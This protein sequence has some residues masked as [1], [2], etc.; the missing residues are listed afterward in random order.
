MEDWFTADQHF[1]HDNIIKYCNRPFNSLP[2]MHEEIIGNWNDCVT[3]HDRVFVL[4]DFAFCNGVEQ[5][6]IE[7][8]LKALRGQKFLI[9]GNH[10]RAPVTHARGWNWVKDLDKISTHGQEIVL[11]HYAMRVWRNSYHGSWALYGHSHSTLPDDVT[12][13]STD[14][15]VDRWRFKPVN[16]EI[17]KNLFANRVFKAVDYHVRKEDGV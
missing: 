4:G 7:K 6:K 17:L 16:Y 10:D 2:E 14:V 1:Y 11:C 5:E 13:L 9:R 15:G 12:S 3:K 8:L